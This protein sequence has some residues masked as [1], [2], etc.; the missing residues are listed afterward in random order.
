MTHQ[1][2]LLAELGITVRTTISALTIMN[3][4]NIPLAIVVSLKT[5]CT[6]IGTLTPMCD[7]VFGQVF[8]IFKFFGARGA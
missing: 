2:L 6:H 3:H 8:T 5:L 7:K 4:Q 1:L